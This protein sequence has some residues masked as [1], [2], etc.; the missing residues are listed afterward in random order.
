MYKTD[1]PQILKSGGVIPDSEC[2]G[3]VREQQWDDRQKLKKVGGNN[4]GFGVP[5]PSEKASFASDDIA[6]ALEPLI[7]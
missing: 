3:Q 1:K 4:S 7:S 2:L 6:E 5:R